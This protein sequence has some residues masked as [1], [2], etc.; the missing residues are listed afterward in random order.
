MAPTIASKVLFSYHPYLA[1]SFETAWAQNETTNQKVKPYY[2]T[3]VIIHIERT[4]LVQYYQGLLGIW[5]TLKQGL[6]SSLNPFFVVLKACISLIA[7]KLI[8]SIYVLMSK[9]QV[10]NVNV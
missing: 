4:I 5:T 1:F 3:L 8:R 7:R 2:H 10:Y 9:V 6:L